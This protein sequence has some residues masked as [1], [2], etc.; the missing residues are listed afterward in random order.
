ME[1]FQK[2]TFRIRSW[3]PTDVP[4][5]VEHANNAN[6]A[7]NLRDS[8][9]YPY[10]EEDATIYINYAIGKSPMQDFAIETD[11]KAMGGISLVPLSDVERFS[12]EIGYWLG[13]SYW[14][15]GIATEVVRTFINYLFHNTSI[16]RLFACVFTHNLPSV[17]VLEK[18]GFRKVGILHKAAY[19][20]NRFVDMYYYERCT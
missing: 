10:T 5:L 13:E 7:N 2:K 8:F 18:N 3:Q 14:N 16:V 4:S 15:K 6:I 9:P 11:G 12:A 1:K 17:R 20:N 19:K